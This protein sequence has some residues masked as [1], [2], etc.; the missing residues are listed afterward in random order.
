MAKNTIGKP[1]SVYVQVKRKPV[2]GEQNSLNFTVYGKFEDI[3]KVIEKALRGK[4]RA[5]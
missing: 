4:I 1:E 3:V 5:A 2:K